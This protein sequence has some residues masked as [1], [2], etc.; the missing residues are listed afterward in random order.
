LLTGFLFEVEPTDPVV[1]GA[2][3]L[4]T[5]AVAL[6]ACVVPVRRAIRVN[7]VVALNSE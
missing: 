7:P 2:V 3:A 1:Y 5:L 6:L 4:L